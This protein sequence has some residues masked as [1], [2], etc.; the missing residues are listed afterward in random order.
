MSA[1]TCRTLANMWKRFRFFPLFDVA[2][3]GTGGGTGGGSGAGAGAGASGQ[4]GGQGASGQPGAGGQAPAAIKLTADSMVD[5][6]DGQPV[7]WGDAVDKEGG[8]FYSSERWQRGLTYL[9]QEAQRLQKAWDDYHAGRGARPAKAEPQP[10]V[11]P[12]DGIR[13]LSS[14]DGRTI[15]RLYNTLQQRGFGPLAQVVAKMAGELNQLKAQLGETARTT[16]SLADR[17]SMAE[18][19][20]FVGKSLGEVG[21]IKGLA[22]GVTL[23][24]ADPFV[25]DAA[26][27]LYLSHEQ[28]SWKPGEFTKQLRGRLEGMIA[29]VRGLDKKAV[30]SAE[31][32]RRSWV[33]GRRGG[34]AQPN[35]EPAFKFQKGADVARQWFS[36]GE[37]RT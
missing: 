32:R 36:Q 14:V 16:G 18:F 13:D 25:R 28:E 29:F 21:Q 11:D 30:E 4:P 31:Q 27:D 9:N 5:L 15:E 34:N 23:D 17:D 3:D 26:K 2:G 12:L 10:Q 19:E 8:R 20:S 6:G 37:Q 33:P 22:D 24:S 35:G 1:R 7:K